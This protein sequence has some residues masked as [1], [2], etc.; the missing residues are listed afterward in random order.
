MQF[1]VPPVE[2]SAEQAKWH[3]T[4]LLD[5]LVVVKVILTKIIM[6]QVYSKVDSIWSTTCGQKIRFL[7]FLSKFS[8]ASGILHSFISLETLAD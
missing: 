7:F 1:Q 4:K 5:L 2:R 6:S 3:G 8:F